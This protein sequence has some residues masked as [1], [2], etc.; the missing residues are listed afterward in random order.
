MTVLQ[1]TFISSVNSTV[2]AERTRVKIMFSKPLPS[3]LIGLIFIVS[4]GLTPNCAANDT[5]R[6]ISMG[7]P[8]AAQIIIKFRNDTPDPSKTD[9]IE[10]LSQDAHAKLVYVRPMSGGTHVFRVENVTDVVQ[11]TEVIE[12]L[13]RN[14]N[15]LYVE[16]DAIMHHQKGK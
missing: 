4:L 11:L 9:F 14:P 12:R 5:Q 13:S 8:G 3:V 1:M 10:Q 7:E 6:Q 2:D 15:V 16:Q